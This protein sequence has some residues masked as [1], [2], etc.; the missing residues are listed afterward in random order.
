MIFIAADHAGLDLKNELIQSLPAI[1]WK[2]LGPFNKDSVDYP[3]FADLVC[4]KLTTQWNA[5]NF[6]VLICGSAQ[7]M[8]MRANKYPHIRAAL[9]WNREIAQLSREHNDANVLCLPARFISPEEATACFNAFQKTNFAQ[10]RHSQRVA[11][12]NKSTHTS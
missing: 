3:D 4:Q 6:G 9:V 2:D 11:K 5:D 1:P 7:G 12:L 10:G 8:A